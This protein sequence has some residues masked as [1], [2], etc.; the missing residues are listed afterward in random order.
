MLLK[1]FPG[2]FYSIFFFSLLLL[3]PLSSLRFC[4]QQIANFINTL[5]GKSKEEK[6]HKL[7][8]FVFLL[9]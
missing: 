2:A 9:M 6:K 1:S 8:P 7:S 5:W 4:S 3:A